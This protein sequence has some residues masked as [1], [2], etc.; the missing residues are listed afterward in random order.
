MFMLGSGYGPT[1]SAPQQAAIAGMAL[2]WAVLPYVF[3]RCVQIV[4]SEAKRKKENDRVIE[5]L[6][7]LER[8]VER[9]I[10]AQRRSNSPAREDSV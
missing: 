10:E 9:L 4:A 6:Q 1:V 8:T 3:S 2:G 5:Q 7:S